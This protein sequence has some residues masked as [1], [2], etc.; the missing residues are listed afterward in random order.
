MVVRILERESGTAG[1]AGLYT[2]IIIHHK[3]QGCQW[4]KGRVRVTYNV[5]TDMPGMIT[6]W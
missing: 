1:R 2:I 6:R 4:R 3:H 5:E